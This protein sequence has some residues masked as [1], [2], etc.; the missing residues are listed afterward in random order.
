MQ[1]ITRT[2]LALVAFATVARA[3]RDYF[4]LREGATFDYAWSYE[5][6]SGVDHLTVRRVE[7][8][9]RTVFYFDATNG[10]RE[11]NII[12]ANHLGLGA[13]EVRPDGIYTRDVFWRHD[14]EAS[15]A[16]S[17]SLLVPLPL[18]PDFRVVVKGQH[19]DVTLTAQG[20]EDVTVRAGTFKRCLKLSV[21]AEGQ[22]GTAW[23]APGVGLVKWKK[24]TGRV[25]EL[26][27]N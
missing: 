8:D 14:L 26:V 3:D 9:G 17:A 22:K 6:R 7:I 21:D 19:H 23:L 5:G 18:R 4:P 10:R 15:R 20:F 13:Y 12:G 2:L 11:S 27:K 1:A 16:D 24:H 25:Q